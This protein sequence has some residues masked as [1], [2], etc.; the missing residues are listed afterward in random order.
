[1]AKSYGYTGYYKPPKTPRTPSLATA[2]A[3]HA[4]GA[5]PFG[6]LTDTTD[7]ARVAR[8]NATPHTP[9]TTI[10]PSTSSAG[11]S[12]NGLGG[13]NVGPHVA[14]AVTPHPAPAAYDINTD[15]A[16][17][18]TNALTGLSDEQAKAEALKQK[19]DELLA[20]GDPNL[21]TKLLGDSTLATAAAGNPSS[22]L[23]QFGQQRDRNVHDMTEYHNKNNTFYGGAR[24]VDEQ[25]AANDYQNAL[26]QAAAGVNSNLGGIESQLAGVLGQSQQSRLAAMQGAYG[27]HATDAGAT[28]PYT[29]TDTGVTDP[30]AS[31]PDPNQAGYGGLTADHFSNSQSLEALLAALVGGPGSPASR[32][33][34]YTG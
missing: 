16:L 22:T 4:T 18:L 29:P 14:P 28:D 34:R 24:I 20:Y 8:Q 10:I 6:L 26:A 13:V 5:D 7:S 33:N 11:V 9:G 19:Q 31:G 2:A 30:A 25:Q 3:G 1:M 27:R 21:I 17:Q 15:P 12:G 23:A 32:L